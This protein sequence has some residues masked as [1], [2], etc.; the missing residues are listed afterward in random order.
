MLDYFAFL[1]FCSAICNLHFCCQFSAMCR[2]DTKRY[3]CPFKVRRAKELWNPTDF[4]TFGFFPFEQ[5]RFLFMLFANHTMLYLVSCT[6][7]LVPCTLSL[8]SC[9]LY[10]VPCILY[11]VIPIYNYCLCIIFAL[12]FF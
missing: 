1:R 6:L 10:L 3:A 8:V 5:L 12:L 11:L 4:L 2:F 7:Y 9:T